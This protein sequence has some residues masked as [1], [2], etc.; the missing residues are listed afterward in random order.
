MREGYI[1]PQFVQSNNRAFRAGR[2]NAFIED[3]GD[4]RLPTYWDVDLR[5]EKTL[6]L[7]GHGRLH[8]I[9]DAFNV[10]N[11]DIVLA[12]HNQVNSAN[13]NK[14][15]EVVEGRTVRFGVRLILR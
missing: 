1:N 9:V 4:T 2:V 13:H 11:N 3:F 7:Q 12:R 15:R 6:D 5:A 10:F 14:I 8:L